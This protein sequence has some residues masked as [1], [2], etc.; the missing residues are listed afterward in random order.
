MNLQDIRIIKSDERGKIFDCGESNFISRKK[1]TISA[2]HK[3][4]D[5]EIIYLVEGEVELT[6]GSETQMIKAPVRFEIASDVY[7]KLLALSDIKL[8]I[9]RADK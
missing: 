4:N 7:H 1:G 9:N 8:I 3:H 2:D 6:I 5:K